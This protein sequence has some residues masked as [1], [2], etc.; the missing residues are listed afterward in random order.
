MSN[1]SASRKFMPAVWI[2]AIAALAALG[3]AGSASLRTH[4]AGTAARQVAAAPGPATVL[5]AQEQGRIRQRLG[6]LPLAF[7]ANQGQ[8]DPQVKYTAR[9]NGYTVFLTANDAIFALESASQWSSAAAGKHGFAKATTTGAKAKAAPPTKDVTADVTAAI[10]MHLVGGNAQPQIVAGSQLPGVTNYYIGSDP[11]QWRTGVK[12]YTGVSYRNVYPGVNM[13][14]HGEQR[15][16]EFD[17]IVAAGASPAP[18]HLGFSGARKIATD[19]SG[20]LLLSSAAGD[21]VMHKPVAFQEINGK[22]QTVAAEFTQVSNHQVGLALGSYDRSRELVIDPS[23]SYATYLGGSNEDEAFAIALDA[24]GNA[25]VTGQTKS[26]TFGGKLQGRPLTSLS[27]NSIPLE[28]LLF[29]RIFLR[30]QEAAQTAQ[31]AALGA[32]PET[33]SLSTA[34]EMRT[35]R[36]VRQRAFRLSQPFRQALA[37]APTMPSC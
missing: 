6:T 10:R 19:A 35:S 9:G 4:S 2:L 36:A 30:P 14:F 37:G 11:S 13:A 3:I 1:P 17:F 22:R 24:S 29:I 18:I 12:Q 33:R 8:T 20:N 27:R 31:Q 28:R 26:P 21:V 7:E 5:S 32:A 16:L 25:Y 34:K 15:Q 23:L